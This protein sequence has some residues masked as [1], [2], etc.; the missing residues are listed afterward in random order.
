MAISTNFMKSGGI[1]PISS[2]QHSSCMRCL[3]ISLLF[4]GNLFGEAKNIYFC[5]Y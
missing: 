1:N 4:P 2:E 5:M 3:N